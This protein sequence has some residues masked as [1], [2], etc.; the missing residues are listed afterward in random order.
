MDTTLTCQTDPLL[1]GVNFNQTFLPA[2]ILT[3]VQG[4]FNHWWVVHTYMNCPLRLL[5]GSLQ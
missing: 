3:S 2:L 1:T 4:K 5:R